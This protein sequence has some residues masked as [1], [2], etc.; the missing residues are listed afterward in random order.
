MIEKLINTK[1][2]DSEKK[3]YNQRKIDY[4]QWVE[5]KKLGLVKI[6]DKIDVR[7]RDY[8]WAVGIV[9]R[10]IFKHENKSKYVIV[11]YEGFPNAFDEELSISSSRVAKFGF[12]TSREGNLSFFLSF[13]YS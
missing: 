10:I 5:N 6:G 1:C 7:T 2:S 13:R 11:H 9:R 4:S 8:V 12:Y 3:D